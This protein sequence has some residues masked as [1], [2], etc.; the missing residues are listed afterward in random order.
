MEAIKEHIKK[1][2]YSHCYLLYGTEDYLKKFYKNKLKS[3]IV[4]DENSMNFSYFEGKAIELHKVIEIAETVPFFSE[5]RLILIENSGLFKNQN[6][7]ADYVKN[8]PDF[9]YIIFVESEVDKRNRLYKAVKDKGTVAELNGLK[10]SEL[11]AWIVAVLSHKGKKIN[12]K[13]L[14]YFKE[15]VGTTMDAMSNELEKLTNYAMDREIITIED[16]DSI[17]T[18]QI[19][20]QIFLMI[21][22]IASQKS[23]RAL[24]LYYDLF[25]LREKPMSILFLIGRHFN[26]LLQ[27]KELASEPKNEVARKAGVPPFAVAKYAAQAGNFKRQDLLQGLG[28]CIEM[29]EQVKKGLLSDQLA[30]ELLIVKLSQ[31]E[32]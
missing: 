28:L 31:K 16:I 4:G 1:N 11:D 14:A 6:D 12:G 27:I 8:I 29:E 13:T 21:D 9:T 23:T 25:A 2:E 17:C 26:I 22:A 10:E 30:V 15:K 18:I 3:G 5:R 19:S 20:N 7:F 24:Q 32:M